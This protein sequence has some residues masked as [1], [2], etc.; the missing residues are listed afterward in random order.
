MLE[1]V[2]MMI[3]RCRAK[4]LFMLVKIQT[5][6]DSNKSASSCAFT[7][8]S[9]RDSIVIFTIHIKRKLS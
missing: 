9:H 5:E 1:S 3:N 7:V 6:N 4:L 8:H 2:M